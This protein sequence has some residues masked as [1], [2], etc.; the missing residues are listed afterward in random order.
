MSHRLSCPRCGNTLDRYDQ[1]RLT[2]DAVVR[3]ADG[4]VLLIK[5]RNPPLGWALPGGFVDVGETLE[6]AVA[7]ELNEETGLTARSLT[8]FHTYSDPAR[9]PR[10]HTV[11]TVF[12]VDAAGKPEA[13][14][15]AILAAFF[16]PDALPTPVVFDHARIIADVVRG[17]VTSGG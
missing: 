1:P 9:D 12:Q 7:R 3:N 14:D 15:D 11:S 17:H 6:R 10:H 5:R 2:V 4:D 8:Q 13:N 16:P